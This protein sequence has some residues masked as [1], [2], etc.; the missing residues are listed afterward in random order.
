MEAITDK[1]L[2]IAEID[3]VLS[4]VTNVSH[5]AQLLFMVDTGLRVS[6]LIALKWSDI[7]IR[8]REVRIRSLKKRG[9]KEAY[10]FV[11]MSER[12]FAA[13]AELVTKK[14]KT[15]TYLFPG[16]ADGKPIT[17]ASVNKWL[18]SLG[19]DHPDLPRDLHP[20]LF[21]HTFATTLRA[22]GAEV[23]DI[24]NLL[25][26]ERQDTTLIYA[27]ADRDRLRT[28]IQAASP[29]PTFWA[30]LRSTL[31]P[32]APARLNLPAVLIPELVGRDEEAK[33]IQK[34]L[35]N[36]ISVIVTGPAGI[37]KKFLLESIS[38]P[39][40]V[41]EIDDISDFKKSIASALVHLLGSKEAVA[42]L[43]YNTTDPNALRTKVGKESLPNLCKLLTDACDKKEYIL[44]IN[45]LDRLTP[46]VA[47]ALDIL[48]DHFVIV[49]SA[50]SIP[51]DKSSFV[52]AFEKLDLKPL[53]RTD[54]LRLFHRLTADLVMQET[55][56]IQTKVWDTSA[57]NPRMTIELAER[58]RTELVIDAYVVDQICNDYLGKQT[59]EIDASPY[60]LLGFGS[61]I[62]FKY[63]GREA[64]EQG[65]TFI[66]S[67]VMVI[68][69]FA[70]YFLRIGKRKSL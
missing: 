52:W 55:E 51:L 39:M 60:L 1:F 12:L 70:R 68:A 14:G 32:V 20:H 10:R 17:R 59:R 4:K 57:G 23:A 28:L 7:N 65:M 40:K 2:T 53:S 46:T 48:K 21:R 49:T 16:N 30:R 31:F 37:G 56:W 62:I 66:G 27:H 44:R 6:E 38:Y 8:K 58:I 50:R 69:L 61:L 47:K 15:D 18:T 29:R 41:L 22:N 63:L 25:G 26:H 67:A 13:L 19:N 5:R 9:E 33:R 64:G 45:D 43:L 42:S 36:K 34:L 54:T 35:A 3:L 11:P 24:Q